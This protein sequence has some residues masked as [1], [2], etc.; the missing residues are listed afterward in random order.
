MKKSKP[1]GATHL[2]QREYD[3]LRTNAPSLV[4]QYARLISVNGD[5]ITFELLGN[6]FDNAGNEWSSGVSGVILERKD[7]VRGDVIPRN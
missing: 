3:S 2:I 5:K 7:I 1:Y 4:Y 6:P